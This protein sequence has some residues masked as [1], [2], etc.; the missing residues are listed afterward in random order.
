[1]LRRTIDDFTEGRITR[2]PQPE[3]PPP[4]PPHAIDPAS[5]PAERVWHVLAGLG[6]RFGALLPV[7][8]GHARSY[9]RA[10]HDR[11]PGMI[12]RTRDGYRV[13]CVDGFVD[14]E[15]LSARARLARILR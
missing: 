8:H 14:V 15:R 4:P 11:R 3:A 1:L 12:E 13:Y 10:A 5:Q 7:P 2:T 6:D 9:A